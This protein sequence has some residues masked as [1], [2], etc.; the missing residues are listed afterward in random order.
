VLAAKWR[1]TVPKNARDHTGSLTKS[2]APF[3]RLAKND[4]REKGCEAFLQL[5][6]NDLCFVGELRFKVGDK[7][8]AHYGAEGNYVNGMIIKQ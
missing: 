4:A 1:S 3:L 6:D 5:A 7:V 2:I 8:K